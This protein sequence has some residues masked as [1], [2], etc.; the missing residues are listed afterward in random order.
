MTMP[1]HTARATQRRRR[2]VALLAGAMVPL[3]LLAG[4]L[5][6]TQF[7]ETEAGWTH[8]VQ[9]EALAEA[10]VIPGVTV[11]SCRRVAG[12]LGSRVEIDWAPPAGYATEDVEI[13]TYTRGLGG[14]L[15]PLTGYDDQFTTVENPD[16]S[17]T[18]TI[19]ANLLGNLVDLGTV[20]Q[21]E[22]VVTDSG[23]TSE[24]AVVVVETFLVLPP[25]VTC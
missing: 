4:M 23:W 5:L 7:E 12:L 10:A 21:V 18:T 19:T 6:P 25:T 22:L 14:V 17:V 20:L 9:A 3:V 1:S 13:R 16:G 11:N 8:Q 24:S 15:E 2:L